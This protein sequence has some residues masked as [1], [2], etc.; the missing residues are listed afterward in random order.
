VFKKVSAFGRE[1]TLAVDEALLLQAIDHPN[2]AA[3]VDVAESPVPARWP[4]TRS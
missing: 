1:T 3:V 4:T 2:V